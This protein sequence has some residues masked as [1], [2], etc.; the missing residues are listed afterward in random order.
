MVCS[1]QLNLTQDRLK[2]RPWRPI[3]ALLL[4]EVYAIRLTS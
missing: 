3:A 1:I 2:K 4:L